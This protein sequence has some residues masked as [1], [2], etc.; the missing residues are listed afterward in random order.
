MNMSESYELAQFIDHT[1]LNNNLSLED[2]QTFCLEAINYGFYSICLQPYYI[3]F[4]FEHIKS[5]KVK[6]VSIVGFPYGTQPISS[7]I[8]E[9]EYLIKNAVDEIDCVMNVSAFLMK[10]Y[11]YIEEEI[12]T[13]SELCHASNV[14]LKVIIETGLLLPEEIAKATRIVCYSG[15]DFVKTS[16]GI[17][18]RGASLE[19]VIIIKENIIGDVKIKASGGIRSLEEIKYFINAGCNRIGTSRAVQIFSE[20]EESEN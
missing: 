14:I 13:L 20:I 7:K 10:N 12:R 15:G 19:D 2:I 4:A 17:V 16:T 18:S 3:P 11:H 8:S 9:A 1:N 6:L 5:T